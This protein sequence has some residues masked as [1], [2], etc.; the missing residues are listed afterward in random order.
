ME[1][2]RS[3][4][5]FVPKTTSLKTLSTAAETC[6]GCDLYKFA[7]QVVFGE[8]PRSAR[9]LLVGEVPGDIEDRQ[10]H[11]FVGPAGRL[12][13]EALVSAEIPRADTYLTNAVKHFKFTPRG[14][15]RI[16]AKPHQLEIE[17]CEPWLLAELEVVKPEI[18]VVLGATAAQALLGRAFRVTQHRGASFESPHAPQTFATVHPAAV[19]R[20]PEGERTQSRQAFFADLA[21]V[22][23]A[24]RAL[25]PR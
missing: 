3:A 13:D 6:R 12:L 7:T 23:K 24:Y 11:P 1:E 20:A 4:A 10:G 25:G 8:G 18:L 16:H 17:A 15:R 5:P 21:A 2:K 14:K 19:L 9:I 22:G